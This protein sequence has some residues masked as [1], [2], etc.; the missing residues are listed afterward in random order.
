[1]PPPPFFI[2]GA[3]RSGTTLLRLMLDRHPEVAIPGESH[4]IPPL[5]ARRRRYGR[6]GSIDDREAWLRDLSAQPAFRRWDLPI[7]LVRREL[8]ALPDPTFA[9]AIEAV[10]LAYAHS[11]G[12]ERWGDKT[13]DYVEHLPLLAHLFPTAR[14]VH[15]IRDGRDVALSTI[16]LQRL[17][18]RAAT[19]AYFWARA[20][21]QGRTAARL[22]GPERYVEV[23]YEELLD[24]PEGEIRRLARFLDLAFHPAMLEHDREARERLP[25]G[26]R[27]IHGRLALPPTKGLRDWRRDMRPSEVEEFEAVAGRELLAAGYEP[28]GRHIGVLARARAWSRM[29]PFGLT[30]AV[31]LLRARRHSRRGVRVPT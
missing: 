19:A 31:R 11:R 26:I 3:A 13:P 21:R 18:R 17:H 5:W 23:R 22:L 1:V 2:V 7:E 20:I 15:L 12:K 27:R 6:A 16:D 9:Q 24:D 29:I 10:F 25:E 4:F 8:D 14:F 28:S 30:Y